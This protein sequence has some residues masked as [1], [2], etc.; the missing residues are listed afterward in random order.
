MN[1]VHRDIKPE[2]FVLE[3]GK[4]FDKIKLIDFAS[5]VKAE[6]DQTLT[7]KL[8]VS[9]AAPEFINRSY[10]SKCDIWAAAAMGYTLLSGK[11]PFKGKR[12]NQMNGREW[13]NIS[14]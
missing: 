11:K 2:S 4:E 13:L 3:K 10:N 5:A 7:E 9:C 12:Q 1:F 6:P 14:D 8:K